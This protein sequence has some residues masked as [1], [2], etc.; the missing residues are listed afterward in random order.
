M[1]MTSQSQKKVLKRRYGQL[2]ENM[3]AY[4]DH[5]NLSRL[6]DFDDDGFAYVISGISAVNMLDLNETKISNETIKLLPGCT[7]TIN[8]K[9]YRTENDQ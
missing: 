9:Y 5:L 4:Y 7:F 1:S 2:V 3:L 6:C 8:G